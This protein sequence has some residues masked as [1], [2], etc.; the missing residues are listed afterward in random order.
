MVAG[1]RTESVDWRDVERRGL[2]RDVLTALAL[3]VAAA[4][5]RLLHPA[6]GPAA[7][8]GWTLAA[9]LGGGA[10]VWLL[11]VLLHPR[12]RGRARERRRAA[13]AVEHHLDPGPSVRERADRYAHQR[14][15]SGSVWWIYLLPLLS[16]LTAANWS[17]PAVTVPS[18]IVLAAWVIGWA[19]W[20]RRTGRA[21]QR[22]VDDPPGP[23]R[24]YHPPAHRYSGRQLAVRIG[25]GLLLAYAVFVAIALTV[26]S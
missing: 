3:P 4:A 11:L 5:W 16:A 6:E 2:Q 25:V 20:L 7:I 14:S 8:V 17:H 26:T 21:A 10:V 12:L 13:F 9:L 1:A 19:L 23:E 15:G 24:E 18:A 22:W